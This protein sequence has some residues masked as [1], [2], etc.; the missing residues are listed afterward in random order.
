MEDPN[1]FWEVE[2]YLWTLGFSHPPD[3]ELRV[4][5]MSG[6]VELTNHR[7]EGPCPEYVMERARRR[8]PVN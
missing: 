1:L 4:W 6:W 2:D 3:S 5:Y 7:P 8:N